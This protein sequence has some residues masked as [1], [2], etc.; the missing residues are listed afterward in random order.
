[1]NT[2]KKLIISPHID[3]E[4]LGC[5]GIL[6]KDCFVL[7]CGFDESHIKSEWVRERP[8]T[9]ERLAELN[10]VQEFLGFEYDILYNKVNHYVVQDLIGSFEKVINE[11]KPEYVYIPNPSYNQDH[12]TVYDA[13]MVALRP[14]DLNHFV[15]KVLIYEQP[16]VYLW[17]NTSR[18]FNANYFVSID[19]ERKLTAYELMAS[20]VRPFRDQTTLKSN[21]YIRGK[22]GNCKYAE[23]FEIIRWVE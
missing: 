12:Q 11:M 7:Y 21:A 3:D 2:T 17:N 18:P 9:N 4:L 23:A 19:I 1:M 20:Q 13:S 8:K 14:H 6:D 15:K 22:Q 5:G 16:Q 10:K